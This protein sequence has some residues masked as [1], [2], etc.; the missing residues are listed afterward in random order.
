MWQKYER[1]SWK[2]ESEQLTVTVTMSICR[3]VHQRILLHE[4]NMGRIAAKYVLSIDQKEHGVAVCSELKEQT[5]K[6]AN[7][8][9][10]VISGDES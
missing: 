6:D 8:I 7:F 9:S 1:L 3:K 2:T 10:T 5:E 4:L